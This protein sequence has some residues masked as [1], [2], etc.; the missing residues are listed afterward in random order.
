MFKVP[1]VELDPGERAELAKSISLRQHTT[2][3]HFPGVHEVE[4]LVNGETR[5]AGSFVVRR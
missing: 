4:V 3:T 2:R 1:Q 5:P